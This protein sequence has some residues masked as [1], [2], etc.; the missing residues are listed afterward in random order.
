MNKKR[1]TLITAL[2]AALALTGCR[3]H[4]EV[5]GV[6]QQRIL[7][8]SRYDAHPDAAA[9]AFIRPY[10]AHVDSIMGPVVGTTARYL[11]A[12]RPEG[13]LSNLL[14]DILMWCA[15]DYGE[16]PDFAVYNIGG[17]RAA[18]AKGPVTV[19]DVVDVAPFE[20]FVCFMTL[21]GDKV[22]ELFRQ[23]AFRGGEGLSH[24]IH[25]VITPNSARTACTLD[26]VTLFGQPINP[27]REYRVATID[28][29][30][31]GT[32]DMVAFKSGTDVKLYQ[33]PQDSMRAI[34]LRYFRELTKEGKLIDAKKEGRVVLTDNR[35]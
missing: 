13:E 12:Y 1:I 32:D 15:K 14:P 35:Q 30:A 6:S 27:T 16:K 19:G 31:G 29:L 24:G 21:R 28:Y 23:I 3:S 33:K 26:S 20:N 5:A 10:K 7:I 18:L 22:L 2:A 11:A 25:L 8:D 17:M 4:Y 34:I 9:E